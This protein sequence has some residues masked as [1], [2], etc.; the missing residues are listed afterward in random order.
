[1]TD[2][3]L[4]FG[5]SNACF[6][7]ALAIVAMAAGAKGKRPY[8]AHML[9]LLV[10]VKLLVPPVVTIP[11]IAI[12]GQGEAAVVVAGDYE[13]EVDEKPGTPEATRGSSVLS[14]V[15]PIWNHAK[16]WFG[17]IWLVGCAVVFTW[18]LVRVCRF[19][20]LLTAESEVAPIQVQAVAV[21]MAERLGLKRVPAIYTTSARLSPLVWWAGWRVRIVIPNALLDEM[22]IWQSRWILAHELAHVRRRDYLVRWLEWLACV[23][24]WWNP[25]V[26][27]AQRNLRAAEEICCDDLVISNLNPKPK[28]Y[29]N[30]LLS[31]VEF[32]ARP[33]LRPPAMASEINSGG[34][35]ERRFTMIMSDNSK[36]KNRR[37]LQVCV[38]ACVMVVLPLGIV[39]AA[40]YEAV[41]KRLKA[42]IEAGE[43]TAHEAEIMLD[44][45]PK[46]D[47]K[48]QVPKTKNEAAKKQAPGTKNEAANKQAPGTKNE[49]AKKQAPK[50]KSET[51]KKQT[52]KTQSGPDLDGVWKKLQAMV[53]SG[54][55]TQE[56]AAAK[57]SAMKNETVRKQV[58]K[59]KDETVNKQVPKTK[60]E[61]A[62]KRAPQ[63]KDETVNKQTPKTKDQT[64]KK[65][66]PKTKSGPDL[67]GVWKKLQVMVASG[68]ITQDQAAAMMSVIKN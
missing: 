4:Q 13:C 33:V 28:M 6:S 51:T 26:W 18:S 64:A 40:D 20:Q 62:K 11:G 14:S 42:A 10:F 9:W 52:P 38:L 7:L 49:T 27:W 57:M 63:T 22:D 21:E 24:F 68:E 32:L 8:L 15:E 34:F 58:P 66:T 35:L 60:Y 48:K 39:S 12:P 56:R 44:A 36:R 19:M 25:V 17:P 41:N 61:V 31:A 2:F 67:D 46:A 16:P 3:F 43:L 23:C 37:L 29:A 53:A 1:M 45:L 54:E 59:T 50:T 30:S 47:A 5:L 65:Q 55:I